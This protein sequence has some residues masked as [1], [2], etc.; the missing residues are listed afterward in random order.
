MNPNGDCKAKQSKA[1]QSKFTSRSMTT[2]YS[3]ISLPEVNLNFEFEFHV[4]FRLVF[5]K[6]SVVV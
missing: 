5:V 4:F 1:K 6:G 3:S 2:I